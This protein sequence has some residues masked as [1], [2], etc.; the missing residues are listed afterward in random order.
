MTRRALGELTR[1]ADYRNATLERA[2]LVHVLEDPR[3]PALALGQSGAP[4]TAGR[5][6]VLAST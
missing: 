5:V 3:A 2:A 1:G 4:E 6:R